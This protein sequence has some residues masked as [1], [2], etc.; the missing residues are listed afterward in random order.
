M[1]EAIPWDVSA[2]AAEGRL[3][4]ALLLGGRVVAQ[5]SPAQTGRRQGTFDTRVL[6][7]GIYTVRA[8]LAAPAQVAQRQVVLAPDPFRW[9]ER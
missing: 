7:P 3:T 1:G 8:T 4:V 6:R 9:S 2:L 5:A